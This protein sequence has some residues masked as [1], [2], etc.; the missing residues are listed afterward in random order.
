MTSVLDRQPTD[1]LCGL[2][3]SQVLHHVDDI[4]S[5]LR[6]LSRRL[7]SDGQLLI[8]DHYMSDHWATRSLDDPS[9]KAI[10]KVVAHKHGQSALCLT[11]PLLA[12]PFRFTTG[13]TSEELKTLLVDVGCFSSVSVKVSQQNDGSTIRALTFTPA[14]PRGDDGRTGKARRC[15]QSCQHAACTRHNDMVDRPMREALSAWQSL[16]ADKVRSQVLS[17]AASSRLIA[18]S[19]LLPPLH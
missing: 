6:A 9:L 11:F 17:I 2:Q 15:S 14:V 13:F 19:L 16:F 12:H 3:V 18:R 7:K 8:I 5:L 1:A 4:P 10:D